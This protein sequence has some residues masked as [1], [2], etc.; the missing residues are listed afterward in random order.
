M[1]YDQNMHRDI[2]AINDMMSAIHDKLKNFHINYCCL[3]RHSTDF[4]DTTNL[5]PFADDLDG[6]KAYVIEPILE[7][8]REAY[9]REHAEVD[10]MEED[11]SAMLRFY[12]AGI[13]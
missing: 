11:E 7:Q 5:G 10:T 1:R 2:E 6:H 8:M 13:R 3:N 4:C 12:Q 9:E